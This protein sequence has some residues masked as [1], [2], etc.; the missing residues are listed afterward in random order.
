M[1]LGRDSS[2]M[3]D[4]A[5]FRVQAP[6]GQEVADASGVRTSLYRDSLG[7]VRLVCGGWPCVGTLIATFEP[8]RRRERQEETS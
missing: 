2:R 3:T 4:A 5:F 1:S 8:R 7:L 6:W